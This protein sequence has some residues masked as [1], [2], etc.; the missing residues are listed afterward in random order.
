MFPSN[1]AAQGPAS[2][3]IL[4]KLRPVRYCVIALW[5][6]FVVKSVFTSPF[7]HFSDLFLAIAGIYLLMNDD[8][9]APCY[10]LFL[11]TPLAF[12]GSG[13][14][15]CAVPFVFMG[16]IDGIFGIFQFLSLF[17][18]GFWTSGL[19]G[20]LYFSAVGVSTFAASFGAYTVYQSLKDIISA[21][22]P[23]NSFSVHPP[24]YV[25]L[26]P[27]TRPSSSGVFAGSAQRLGDV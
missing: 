18:S 7:A 6:S 1:P 3:E 4:A 26:A 8:K 11:R 19:R 21:R 13:G 27:N 16:A 9:L 17:T 5:A 10:A 15:R 24:Q 22:P 2:A 12:C 20:I 14:L 23:E 25:S